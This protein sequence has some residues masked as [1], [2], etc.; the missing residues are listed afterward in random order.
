MAISNGLIV[1]TKNHALVFKSP[2]VDKVVDE[3]SVRPR[4]G[5]SHSWRKLHCE[6]NMCVAPFVP[7]AYVAQSSLIDSAQVYLASF[8]LTD[9]TLGGQSWL[10]WERE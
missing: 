1:K 3:V 7:G 4:D 5:E 9:E 8:S 10:D 2:D 6:R